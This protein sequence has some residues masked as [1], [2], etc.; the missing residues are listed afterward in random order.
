MCGTASRQS[1]RRSAEL[2][3]RRSEH[4]VYLETRRTGGAWVHRAYMAK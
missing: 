1:L 2:E 4:A 3:T